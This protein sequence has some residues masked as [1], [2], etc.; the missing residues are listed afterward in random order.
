MTLSDKKLLF[1]AQNIEMRFPST[2]ALQGIDME[3]CEGEVI[4][5]VGE[6]GAGKSTLLKIIMGV[7]RQTDGTMEMHGKPYEPKSPREANDAGVGMVFQ[8]Q[9]LVGNLTVGQNIFFG[10]EKN[11]RIGPIMNWKK[12]YHDTEKVFAEHDIQGI[13]PS[14][15]VNDYDFATRQMIEISKVISRATSGDPSRKSVILLDE[16]TSVLSAQEIQKLF[17]EIRKLTAQGHAVVFVSHRLDEIINISDRVYIFKDGRGVG[18]FTHEELSEELLYE[19]MVGKTTSK[20]YYK[21]N[22]QCAP[23]NDAVLE[24]RN[25]G[26][27]G[28]FKNVSFC[29]H[30]SEV[31]GICGVVGA[32]KEELC[33]VL[34][35]LEGHTTGEIVLEGKPVRFGQVSQAVSAGIVSIPKERREEGQLGS[36]SIYENI[37]ISNPKAFR[38]GAL[39]SEK[40]QREVTDHWIKEMKIRCSG[41]DSDMNS[42]S[43]G[44][45]QK[46]VFARALC[47]GAKVL[48]LNHPTR[49]VDVGA[50]EEIYSLIRDATEQ[51]I[52]VIVLGD[53]LDE[54][55]GLSN[56]I[57]TM[58]DGLVTKEFICQVG[59]KPE[60]VDIVKGMM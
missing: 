10:Q 45:A 18:Q 34:A 7:Q 55:I 22:R 41:M 19:R 14:K 1:K 53:T 17:Q 3:I 58:K 60:Q 28:Y 35:G 27:Y 48:I 43:G 11:Y 39:I 46:V 13:K 8:E 44:N 31:L 50:K 57:L 36:L 24:V 12:M 32:G 33:D 42:L 16:P 30:K 47:A 5:L 51:G 6:N 2:L 49:G 59:H 25:L 9:A 56:R 20:E 54:C 23:E 40:K 37:S 21:E 4:G 29:L 26:L 15:K 52:A 38:K